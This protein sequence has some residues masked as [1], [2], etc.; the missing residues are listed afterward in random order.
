VIKVILANK[1]TYSVKPSNWRGRGERKKK[2]KRSGVLRQL[3]RIKKSWR[4]CGIISRITAIKKEAPARLPHGQG[5]RE[6]K[7]RKG[8]GNSAFVGC[9]EI[10]KG[11]ASGPGLFDR[12]PAVPSKQEAQAFTINSFLDAQKGKKKKRGEEKGSNTSR[13]R[14]RAT[15]ADGLD[16]ED[17]ASHRTEGISNLELSV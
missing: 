15:G 1:D 10:T 17:Q 13:R 6:R 16:R 4:S 2:E 7:K 9:K 12:P 3:T 11:S 5:P 14:K 8:G